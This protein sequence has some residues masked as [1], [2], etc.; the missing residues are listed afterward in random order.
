MKQ[1]RMRASFLHMESEML[2]GLVILGVVGRPG[3]FN[4]VS[5][6]WV[7]EFK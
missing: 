2:V 1:A 6:L 3:P 7:I 4:A 5:N